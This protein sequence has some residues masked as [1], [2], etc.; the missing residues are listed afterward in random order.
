[1]IGEDYEAIAYYSDDS[2][3]AYF[4]FMTFD[5][6]FLLKSKV[7]KNYS[8]DLKIRKIG[9]L[10]GKDYFV[11]LMEDR[12]SLEGIYLSLVEKETLNEGDKW[13]ISDKGIE[14]DFC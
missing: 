5:T 8:K 12:N 10:E 7:V 14:S 3:K 6:N 13:V 2:I 9:W 11:S 1:M 4:V